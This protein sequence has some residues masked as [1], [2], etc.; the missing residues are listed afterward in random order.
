MTPRELAELIAALPSEAMDLE[1][2]VDLDV[3]YPSGEPGA[4]DWFV[5]PRILSLKVHDKPG[6]R[7]FV[8]MEVSG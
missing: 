2:E 5:S 1:I 7:F 6:D 8:L 3:T 4:E